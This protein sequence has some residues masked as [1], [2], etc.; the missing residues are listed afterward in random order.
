MNITNPTNN[1]TIRWPRPA[2]PR[3]SDLP[4]PHRNLTSAS[5]ISR[6]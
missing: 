5:M 6:S 1:E 4:D 3:G 2:I